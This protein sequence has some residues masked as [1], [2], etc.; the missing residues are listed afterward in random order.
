MQQYKFQWA[1]PFN[2]HTGVGQTF[3]GVYKFQIPEGFLIFNLF[4]GGSAHIIF[5]NNFQEHH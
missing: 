5:V 1:I 2:I 3:P 4:P